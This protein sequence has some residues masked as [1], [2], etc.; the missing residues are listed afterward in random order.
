MV[1]SDRMI[2]RLGGRVQREGAGTD[3]VVEALAR[4]A[5][6]EDAAAGRPGTGLGAG[7]FF[8]QTIG[9]AIAMEE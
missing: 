2:G 7:T 1:V 9:V 8:C 6:L 3:Q 5:S 4:A